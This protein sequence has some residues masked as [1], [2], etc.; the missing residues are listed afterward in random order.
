MAVSPSPLVGSTRNTDQASLIEL[1]QR[2][3]NETK[4]ELNDKKHSYMYSS[5]SLAIDDDNKDA[6]Q[7]LSTLLYLCVTMEKVDGI[8][9][10]LLH[11]N[12]G[13]YEEWRPLFDSLHS[14]SSKLQERLIHNDRVKQT[15]RRKQHYK[16]E[17]EKSQVDHEKF[18]VEAERIRQESKLS[19]EQLNSTVSTLT[20]TLSKLEQRLLEKENEC[21]SIVVDAQAQREEHN[22]ELAEAKEESTELQQKLE[23]K[24][25]E[26]Q[27]VREELMVAIEKY[28]QESSVASESLDRA[29]KEGE[30]SKAMLEETRKEL[31]E[32]DE[33]YVSSISE[34]RESISSIEQ[35]QLQPIPLASIVSLLEEQAMCPCKAK[36][37]QKDLA[38][39]IVDTAMSEAIDSAVSS[40]DPEGVM[41]ET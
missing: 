41:E 20:D 12:P 21:K 29:I 40:Q 34:L 28:R 11:Q 24:E 23:S 3:F 22:K 13:L 26:L 2:K 6:S 36:E 35:K 37:A 15:Y 8:K 27:S 7:L 1:A 32:K 17:L 9:Q 19:V 14:P 18:M 33:T 30:E 16:D 25:K 5:K 38:V 10:M 4:Q 31:R 39:V